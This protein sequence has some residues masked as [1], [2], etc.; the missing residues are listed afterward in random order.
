M[1]VEALRAQISRLENEKR[2]LL[3]RQASVN[4]IIGIDK[5]KPV[6]D[7][8]N[9]RKHSRKMAERILDSVRISSNFSSLSDKCL[10]K[11]ANGCG[12]DHW[13]ERGELSKELDRIQQRIQEIDSEIY[14]LWQQIE[15]EE[16]Q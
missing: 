4:A 5:T 3:E 7:I 10:D 12:L 14:R 15:S 11:A 6:D 2:R 8:D 9:I 1:S 13:E 16:S